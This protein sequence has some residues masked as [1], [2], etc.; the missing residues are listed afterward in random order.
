[1]T[2]LMYTFK[3]KKIPFYKYSKHCWILLPLYNYSSVDAFSVNNSTCIYYLPPRHR[4]GTG[5]IE[6]PPVRPSVCLSVHHVWFS[7][8]DSKTHCCI[9]SK[10]MGCLNFA[11]I[12][13]ILKKRNLLDLF[14]SFHVF[15]VL[16]AISN[17][18]RKIILSHL[19]LSFMLFPT[20]KKKSF[21]LGNIEKWFPWGGGGNFFFR[22]TIL[23]HFILCFMLFPTFKK[24]K[25]YWK[26]P[27]HLLVK[28]EVAS[29]N[30]R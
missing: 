1:M 29:P 24:K 26:V 11:W 25:G 4:P 18:F 3:E 6:T 20:F 16:C 17:I 15:F 23:S 21:I 14:F 22:K 27:I 7:H 5:D 8:S 19:I 2:C 28:W 30:S 12:F 10:L 9:F 13:E